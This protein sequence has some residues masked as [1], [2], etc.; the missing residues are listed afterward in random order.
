MEKLIHTYIEYVTNY[1]IQFKII[2][3]V[4]INLGIFSLSS[5]ELP[6]ASPLKIKLHKL[7]HPSL[8]QYS[9]RRPKHHAGTNSRKLS[10]QQRAIL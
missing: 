10:S 5:C 2:K 9:S 1:H 6:D 3:Y 4:T 7:A 8:I